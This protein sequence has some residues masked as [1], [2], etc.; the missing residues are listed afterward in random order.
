M[1]CM[2]CVKGAI[3]LSFLPESSNF[4][5][6]YIER[7]DVFIQAVM[8][9]CDSVVASEHMSFNIT[10]EHES[11]GRLASMNGVIPNFESVLPIRSWANDLAKKT[12]RVFLP[13]Q[14]EE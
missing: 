5:M 12:N 2:P 8:A 9:V 11:A 1:C 4:S 13:E 14:I 6:F 3:L 7:D 10:T